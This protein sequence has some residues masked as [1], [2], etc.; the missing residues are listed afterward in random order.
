[1]R[2]LV[3]GSHGLIGTAVVDALRKRG[4]DV[5]PLSR[6]SG[7]DPE[8]GTIDREL[9]AGHDAVVHLAGESLGERRWTDE[10]KRRIM[11][12]RRAGT[13][14]L[15]GALADL[16]GDARPSVLVSASAIGIYGDRGDE[17][18]T[19]SSSAGH[20]FLTDV[21]R[22]WE[23]A[24]APAAVA[25]IRVVHPRTGIVLSSRGGALARQLLPFRLGLGGPL[26]GGRQWWS[27]VS[28]DDE[29]AA[30][31]HCIDTPAISGPVNVVAPAPVTQREFASTFGRVLHRPAVLPTPLLPLRLV[32]GGE[33]VSE[34][35]LWS[36]RVSPGVLTASGFAFRH[37]VLEEAL[38]AVAL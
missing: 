1:M 37:P 26:G 36:Q 20:G 31:L 35:L 34:V 8:A 28:L 32:Y 25:G 9:I 21:V 6:P 5:T 33:L 10:Q 3:T 12:S 27:W 11:D 17:T 29:V 19:E 14:L 24:A 7:W 16:A 23:A 2:V 30:I 4:D 38:R 15:A 13:S 22:E 18:L